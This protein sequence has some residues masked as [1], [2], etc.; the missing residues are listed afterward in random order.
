MFDIKNKAPAQ[1]LTDCSWWNQ[2]KA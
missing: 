2:T 1:V